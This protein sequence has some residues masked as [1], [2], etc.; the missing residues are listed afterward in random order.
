MAQALD[1]TLP[2]LLVDAGED[3]LVLL[4]EEESEDTNF[5]YLNLRKVLESTDSYLTCP[6]Q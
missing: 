5:T 1:P 3:K 6:S 4:M 2:L